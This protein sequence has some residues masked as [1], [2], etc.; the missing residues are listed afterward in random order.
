[1]A[2]RATKKS[3]ECVSGT[4]M[5]RPS[6]EMRTLSLP[7]A[8]NRRPGRSKRSVTPLTVTFDSN[9]LECLAE[10]ALNLALPMAFAG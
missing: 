4:F 7:V 6:R 8:G 10:S 2:P 3:R 1:M 5:G 9:A